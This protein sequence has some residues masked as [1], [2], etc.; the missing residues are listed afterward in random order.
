MLNYLRFW[1]N[2]DRN[3]STRNK[4]HIWKKKM[5]KNS[6]SK[7]RED[8]K[9]NQKES[10]E[11]KATVTKRKSSVTEEKKRKDF[12]PEVKTIGLT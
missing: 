5:G 2:H 4:E 6:L 3:A 8:I 12:E 9:K 1:S 11:L 10:L 7:D